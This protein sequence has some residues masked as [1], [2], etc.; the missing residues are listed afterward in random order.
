ME[1]TSLLYN[2]Q[3]EEEKILFCHP[4]GKVYQ[5]MILL[6]ICFICFGNYFAYD[7]IEPIAK[8]YLKPVC[9]EIY[10]LLLIFLLCFKKK[11]IIYLFF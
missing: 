1:E 3:D 9:K 11:K 6:I 2:K 10:I 7:Q 5:Y 8:G 4:K